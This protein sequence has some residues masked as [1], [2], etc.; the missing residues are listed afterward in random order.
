MAELLVDDTSLNGYS[1]P[2]S[3]EVLTS[4]VD[5]LR[6]TMAYPPSPTIRRLAE[7]TLKSI[8]RIQ[9]GAHL[10]EVSEFVA[11]R[12]RVSLEDLQ[13][14]SRT[15][16]I[17]FARMIAMYLCRKLSTCSF[18]SIAAHFNRDH[19]TA[20]HAFNLIARRIETDLPFRRTIERLEHE[21]AVYTSPVATAAA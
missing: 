14:K 1:Q 17:T 15:Q 5:A 8:H 18:P 20:I 21:L 3:D 19:S 2:P 16:R 10:A 6:A 12:F 4:L 7:D 13:S 9:H 11:M